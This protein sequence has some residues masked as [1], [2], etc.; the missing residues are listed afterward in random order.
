MRGGSGDEGTVGSAGK[1]VYRFKIEGHIP[2]NHLLRKIDW[3]LDFDAI[4]HELADLD[5][6]T[7]RPLSIPS[8]YCGCCWSAI[9]MAPDLSGD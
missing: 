3:L 7:G 5:S 1:L 2:S 4:R 9:F 8:C 6:H